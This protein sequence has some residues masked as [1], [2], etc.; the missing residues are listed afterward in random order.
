MA[1][2]LADAD[3]LHPGQASAYNTIMGAAA[4][5]GPETVTGKNLIFI[6]SP[7]GTGKVVPVQYSNR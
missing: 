2:A 1:K 5:V 3:K 6:E 7:G 4:D